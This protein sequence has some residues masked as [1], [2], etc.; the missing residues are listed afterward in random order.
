MC[1]RAC[2]VQWPRYRVHFEPWP[3]CV[4]LLKSNYFINNSYA[5]DDEGDNPWQATE[6]S[7]VSSINCDHCWRLYILNTVRCPYVRASVTV[8][9]ASSVADAVDKSDVLMRM[10]TASTASAIGTRRHNENDVTMTIAGLWRYVD[11]RRGHGLH[12]SNL[13]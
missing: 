1:S 12:R 9:V 4:R 7:T 10:G 13:N 8:G 6:V 5:R 2:H 3:G 11:W